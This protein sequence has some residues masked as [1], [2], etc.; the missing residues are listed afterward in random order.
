[1]WLTGRRAGGQFRGEL[2]HAGP[3]RGPILDGGPN[4]GQDVAQIVGELREALGVGL[5]QE[6][7]VDHRFGDRARRRRGRRRRRLGREHLGEDPVAVTHDAQHRV[8][9]QLDRVAPPDQPHRHR[10]HEERHVVADDLDR[11]VG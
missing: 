9:E 3:H 7:D 10:V 11:A 4:L 2:G 6:L 5:A 8:D 1:M